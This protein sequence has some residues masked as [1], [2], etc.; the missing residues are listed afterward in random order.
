MIT[1]Q[2]LLESIRKALEN[3]NVG[4]E[5]NSENTEGWDSLGQLS[6][7]SELDRITDGRS[8]EIDDLAVCMSVEQLSEKLKSDKL[9]LD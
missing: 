6:I 5:S 7:L 2:A 4:F 3:E 8:S 9:L 1:S